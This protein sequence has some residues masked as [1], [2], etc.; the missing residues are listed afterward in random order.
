VDPERAQVDVIVDYETLVES[1]GGTAEVAPGRVITG[2]AARRLACDA[3][4]ARIITRGRS[5]VLDVGR[6]SRHWNAAQRRAIRY[7]HGN[8]CAIRGCESTIVQIHH[9]DWW[10]HGGRTDLDL[11]V[12]LCHGHHRLVHEGGWEVFL[13]ADRTSA[14]LHR[15]G[16]HRRTAPPVRRAA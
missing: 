3:G 5:E 16:R 12:P 10:H 4:I 15:T 13:S 9:L 14:T 6:R 2:D 7:R 8:R 11:G 1:A